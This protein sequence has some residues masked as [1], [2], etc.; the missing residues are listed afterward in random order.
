MIEERPDL[1]GLRLEGQGKYK[2]VLFVCSGGMQRSVKVTADLR[3][4]LPQR[5]LQQPCS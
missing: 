1:S 5:N 2:R 3:L 4:A